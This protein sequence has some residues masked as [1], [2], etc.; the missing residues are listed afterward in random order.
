MYIKEENGKVTIY[1][2]KVS[3]DLKKIR[4][5]LIKKYGTVT[6]FT[7]ESTNPYCYLFNHENE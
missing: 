5:E 4:D 6:E 3:E 2:I 1:E 7:K